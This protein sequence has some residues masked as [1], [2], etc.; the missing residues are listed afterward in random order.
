MSDERLDRLIDEVAH[1]MTAGQLSSDFRARVI[2]R[3]DRRPRRGWRA[4]WVVAPLG[5]AAAIVL[6]VFVARGLPLRIPGFQTAEN[7]QSSQAAPRRPGPSAPPDIAGRQV[8]PSAPPNASPINRPD[9]RPVRN[10]PR[11]RADPTADVI[12]AAGI[13]P[14]SPQPIQVA[15][16]GIEALSTESIT[17]SQL[18]AI[19]PIAVDPLPINEQRP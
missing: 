17:V 13:D 14:L 15:P 3:L 16:L 6:A 9:V 18:D 12:R 8:Q 4:L 5:A 7:I 1:E 2:A 11:T 10:G 19:V